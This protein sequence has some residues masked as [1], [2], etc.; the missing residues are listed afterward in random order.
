M[1]RQSAHNNFSNIAHYRLNIVY[2]EFNIVVKQ[3]HNINMNNKN[4]KPYMSVE[5]ILLLS[6]IIYKL[7]S[8]LSNHLFV[9]FIFP[10][11]STTYDMGK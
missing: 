11:F 8:V 7:R 4:W 6:R 1:S 9:I 2:V 10:V 5:Y 3:V